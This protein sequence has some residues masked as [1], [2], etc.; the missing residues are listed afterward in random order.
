M[1]M[2]IF[3]LQQTMADVPT[4][5]AWLCA[6]EVLRLSEMKFTKRCNDWRLGRWTA[7][8]AISEY[9]VGPRKAALWTTLK[10]ALPRRV[11]PKSLLPTGGRH[12]GFRSVT[13]VVGQSLPSPPQRWPWVAIWKESSRAL[14]CL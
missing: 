8:C 14:T 2:S 9:L 3:W 1:L 7:K 13:V 12:L 10:Y 11:L 5:N 6:R 4:D